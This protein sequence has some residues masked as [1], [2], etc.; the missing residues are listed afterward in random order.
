MKKKV[1]NKAVRKL[2]SGMYRSDKRMNA[3]ASVAI[4]LS[5]MLVILV[6]STI[7]S[8]SNL[9]SREKQMMAGT[10]AEGIYMNTSYYW[11]EKLRDS[12]HFDAV[13]MTASM[14]TYE[15]ESSEGSRNKILYAEEKTAEWNFN[16]LLEGSWPESMYEIAVDEHF[17]EENGGEIHAG[18]RMKI[19]LSTA[20]NEIEQEMVITGICTANDALEENRIYVSDEFFQWDRSGYGINTYCRFES[21]RY[22]VDDLEGFLK[23]INQD[24]KIRIFINP[25]AGNVSKSI[26]GLVSGLIALTVVCAGLMIYIIYYISIVKNVKQYGQLKLIGVTERQIRGIL[27]LQAMRQYL[28]GFP[29]G[30]VLG[31]V[32]GYVLMPFFASFAG[33]M[34]SRTLTIRPVYF[35]CAAVIS[36]IVVYVGIRKPMKILA[37]I[38]PVHTVGFTGIGG[39]REGRLHSRPFTA[40]RFA[41]RSIKTRRKKTVL[42]ITSISVVMILFVCTM[43]LVN[44]LNV[45]K[46]VGL[47]NLFAD[48][49]IATEDALD[50]L[51][52]G[53]FGK[54]EEIPSEL[55]DMLDGVSKDME[56]TYH[57]NLDTM[58]FLYSED[59]EG[60][61]GILLDDGTYRSNAGDDDV[62]LERALEYREG[63]SEGIFVQQTYRF[64]E[65]DQIDDFEV[66]DGTLDKEKFESGQYVIAVAFTEEGDSYYHAG[67]V[68]NLINE[69]PEESE[70]NYEK[71]ENGHYA[72]WDNLAT[73]EYTVLAVVS[74][75]Y[76]NLM[77][78]G[79]QC[80]GDFEFILP[81]QSM[82][83]MSK[84]PE[85]FM[86]TMDAP[87]TDTL[88]A[89]EPQV[90]KFLDN[91]GGEEVVAYRS[92]GIYK[93]QLEE[94][95]LRLALIGNGFAL[96]VGMMAL[97]NFF[98]SCVSGIAARKEE[99]ATLQAIGMTK[100]QLL[101]VLRRENLYTVLWAVI[102]GYLIGH[103]VSA[104]V[105]S[106]VSAGIG[107]LALDVTLLPG[108]IL[109]ITACLLSMVYPNRRTDLGDRADG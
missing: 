71:D 91:L 77:Q 90:E 57:Y 52:V 82:E 47:T 39:K 19:K 80:H 72:F 109:A 107:Y 20:V 99:F 63:K 83:K 84:E 97:V 42:V 17:V 93:R 46:L 108:I 49:E 45:E 35:L 7:M 89:V 73:K 85:L 105:I 88:E 103:L 96:L 67:D 106:R 37:K 60:Y 5:A 18:D 64:Y 31:C 87:D 69:F 48:I 27:W 28:I 10:Q 101:G 95:G 24:A 86:V 32:A 15:T 74:D 26:V 44:S 21:G 92:K 33:L 66:F 68:V 78:A 38:P 56:V 50:G 58:T 30:C 16:A 29:A 25:G 76:R 70:V 1:I 43:N 54:A 59:A 40:G 14:G 6:L 104:G 12:G 75:G 65:Y 3:T 22:N 81:T 4:A 8:V 51:T 13:A 34:Y 9:M 55:H 11:F 102:P 62:M 100:R 23:E 41:L 53:F 79:N 2:S 98:N 61:C 94:F 36:F